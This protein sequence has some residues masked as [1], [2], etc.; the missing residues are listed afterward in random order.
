[1]G[2]S[3]KVSESGDYIVLRVTGAF[4]GPDMMNYIMEAHD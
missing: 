3:I 1:M 4:K 2:Y